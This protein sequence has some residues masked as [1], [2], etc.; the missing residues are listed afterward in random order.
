VTIPKASTAS[1]VE[2]NRKAADL[3]LTEADV[4]EVAAAFPVRAGGELHSV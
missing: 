3:V 2:A 1:H 4:R